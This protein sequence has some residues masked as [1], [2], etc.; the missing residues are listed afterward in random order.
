[1][2]AVQDLRNHYSELKTE[3]A[4]LDKRRKRIRRREREQAARLHSS[5]NH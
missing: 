2:Q 5:R 4:T 1:M 3:L